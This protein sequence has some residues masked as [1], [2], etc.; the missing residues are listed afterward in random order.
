MPQ[1]TDP[2][3]YQDLIEGILYPALTTPKK[4]TCLTKQ[5]AFNL[6]M[7]LH[8]AVK[9]LRRQ[10]TEVLDREHPR[11]GRSDFDN[12]VIQVDGPMLYVRPGNPEL[13]Q[14]NLGVIIE[15]LLE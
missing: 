9:I 7:R 12:L 11:Y 13:L 15:D 2:L 14:Q 3:K 5:Q 6:K 1:S 4:I 8:T 10:S